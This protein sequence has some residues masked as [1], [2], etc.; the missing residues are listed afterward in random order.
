VC[1]VIVGG[2][3]GE[4]NVVRCRYE[5]LRIVSVN[6]YCVCEN[7]VANL[8]RPNWERA[9]EDD[10]EHIAI[11]GFTALLCNSYMQPVILYG[12]S[13]RMPWRTDVF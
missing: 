4:Q 10:R 2:S 12:H 3:A 1:F 9:R 11:L 8:E 6:Y 13:Q 7:S 5:V